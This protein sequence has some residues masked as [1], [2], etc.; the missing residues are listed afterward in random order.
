MRQTLLMLAFLLPLPPFPAA[1]LQGQNS[2]PGQP[3]A[4][5][6][7]VLRRMQDSWNKGDLE[8]FLG[9]Y[10]DSPELTFFSNGRRLAGRTTLASTLRQRYAQDTGRI[11]FGEPHFG[12][13]G[14]DFAV[15]WGDWRMELKN[16]ITRNGVGTA[17]FRYIDGRW[18]I[19]HDHTSFVDAPSSTH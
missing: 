19:V 15:I 18:R 1:V 3:Q 6:R 16:G 13:V 10:W 11:V 7:A 12:L 4:E 2:D 17:V 8:Q 9:A 14:S 5:V